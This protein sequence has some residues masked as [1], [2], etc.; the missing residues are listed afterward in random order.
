[1]TTIFILIG[2]AIFVILA[3]FLTENEQFGWAT[4]MLVAS[5]VTVQ[6]LHVVDILHY[7]QGH[8][9]E[10]MLYVAGYILVGVLWSF[11]KWFLYLMNFREKFRD[12]KAAFLYSK[13]LNPY[14]QVPLEYI[15]GFNMYLNSVLRYS[16]D[17]SFRGGAIKRP[18]AADNKSRI[19]AWMSLWP[20]SFIGTMLNDPMRRLFNFL[21][22]FFR[23]LYQRMADSIF[24]NDV[25]LK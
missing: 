11:V 24:A 15:E 12:C 22:S 19:I 7:V 4:I 16:D 3:T 23:S 20:V 14:G 9:G 6:L 10:T 2:L 25:E 17:L 21:F 13:K 5:L 18:Q 8:A 1:M